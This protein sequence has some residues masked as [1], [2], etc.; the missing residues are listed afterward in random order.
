MILLMLAGLLALPV[1]AQLLP[2]PPTPPIDLDNIGG[3]DQRRAQPPSVKIS[4]RRA[5]EIA[6]QAYGGNV[7]RISL[8]GQGANMRYQLRMENEGKIFTVFVDANTGAIS[9]GG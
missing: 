6:R 9:G 1:Y 5:V 7:L 8:I 2:P 3:N 4:E